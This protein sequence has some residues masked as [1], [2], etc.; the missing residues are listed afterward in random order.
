MKQKGK[1]SKI[2]FKFLKKWMKKKETKQRAKEIEKK[3]YFKK[4]SL[5]SLSG[6]QTCIQ[7]NKNNLLLLFFLIMKHI[8]KTKFF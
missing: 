3:P 5:C 2:I 4:K 1:Y 6:L 8:R 7:S